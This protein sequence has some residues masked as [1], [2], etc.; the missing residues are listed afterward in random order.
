MNHS[1]YAKEAGNVHTVGGG[2]GA[3]ELDTVK[4]S[5]GLEL[6]LGTEDWAG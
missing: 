2:A 1:G 6:I 3:A 5:F 4:N